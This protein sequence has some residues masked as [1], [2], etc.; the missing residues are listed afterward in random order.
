MNLSATSATLLVSSHPSFRW[1]S[2]A[3]DFK[4]QVKLD[5]EIDVVLAVTLSIFSFYLLITT[6]TYYVKHSQIS[7]LWTN[8]ICCLSAFLLFFGTCWYQTE[9][10]LQN[11]TSIF[12]GV[13]T[14]VNVVRS[15]GNRTLVYIVLWIRLRNFYKTFTKISKARFDSLS[16]GLLATIVLLSFVQIF[17][18]VSLPSMAGKEGCKSGKPSSFLEI[19][20][21]IVFVIFS[22]FQVSITL[23]FVF[24][25][26]QEYSDR[27]NV[28]KNF[29]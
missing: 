8:R 25:F 23:F 2:Q 9:I 3:S 6:F 5:R 4:S 24:S 18:L 16:Y 14:I 20:T 11:H 29:V 22:L 13:Y 21:P 28:A 17:T 1:N 10:Q 19:F 12:C 15:I 7:L 27:R 26:N